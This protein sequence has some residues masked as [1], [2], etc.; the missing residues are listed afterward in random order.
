MRAAMTSVRP[1]STGRASPSSTAT[2]AAR[3]TRSSS[4]SAYT[5]RFGACL[6]AANTGSIVVPDW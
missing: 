4:P 1:T 3:S 6:A 5:T 2:C